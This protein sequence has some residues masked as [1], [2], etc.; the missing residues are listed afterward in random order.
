MWT[1]GKEGLLC[2]ESR[3][4]SRLQRPSVPSPGLC[5]SLTFPQGTKLL[6]GTAV[7]QHTDLRQTD[8][9]FL[10]LHRLLIM[11][12][13]E[14]DGIGE[15][16]SEIWVHRGSQS[17]CRE[18]LEAPQPSPTPGTLSRPTLEADL[19]KG[20]WKWTALG[21]QHSLGRLTCPGVRYIV[22]HLQ[23]DEERR[24]GE[25]HV[26]LTAQAQVVVSCG[27]DRKAVSRARCRPA[28]YAGSPALK[29]SGFRVSEAR[30]QVLAV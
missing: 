28:L 19:R 29:A 3:L 23:E 14:L 15:G 6:G 21:S 24:H 5:P 13:E 22:F 17:W 20:E 8:H 1:P 25:G 12:S 11:G 18:C 16:H 2:R 9:G 27:H 10:E 30:V 26:A 7:D 4:G